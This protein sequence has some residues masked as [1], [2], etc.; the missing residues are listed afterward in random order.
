MVKGTI[1]KED[2]TFIN[3]LASIMGAPKYIKLLLTDIKWKNDCNAP[4]ISMD[5]SSR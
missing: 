2:I 3:I 1:H 4:L 5:R